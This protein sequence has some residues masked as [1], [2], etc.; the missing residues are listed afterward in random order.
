MREA[1]LADLKIDEVITDASLSIG[2]SPI[3]ERIAHVKFWI[4]PRKFEHS[5]HVEDSNLDGQI[6]YKELSCELQLGR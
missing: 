2:T 5:C 6:P 1:E 3:T 4:N